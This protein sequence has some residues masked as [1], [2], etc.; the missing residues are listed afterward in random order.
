MGTS[1][2]E[3]KDPCGIG[4]TMQPKLLERGICLNCSVQS[5]TACVQHFDASAAAERCTDNRLRDRQILSRCTWIP[6]KFVTKD[7]NNPP[8]PRPKT[9]K[10][11]GRV[12]GFENTQSET[13]KRYGWIVR[14]HVLYT[15]TLMSLRGIWR[16]PIRSQPAEGRRST[17]TFG[18]QMGSTQTTSLAKR[19]AE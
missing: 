10:R 8:C 12:V 13:L 9:L 18:T 5:C 6:K 3:N 16:D 15:P 2:A 14:H 1:D 17:S 19:N 11:Y 4:P 7:P